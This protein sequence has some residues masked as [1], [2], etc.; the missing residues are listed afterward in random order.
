VYVQNNSGGAERISQLE[1]MV[2]MKI[3]AGDFSDMLHGAV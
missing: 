2:I 1:E 3:I